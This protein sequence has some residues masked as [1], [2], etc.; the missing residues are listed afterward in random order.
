MANAFVYQFT[1]KE[2]S[3]LVFKKKICPKCGG[4]MTRKKCSEITNGSRFVSTH[5]DINLK[6]RLVKHYYYT[7]VCDDC[8]TEFELAD[9]VEQK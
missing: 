8:G 4:K 2:V 9:L 3:Y 6:N 1:F 5:D 7:F